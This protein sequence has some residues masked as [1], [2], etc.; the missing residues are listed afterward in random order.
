MELNAISKEITDQIS[1]YVEANEF[2]LRRYVPLA[3][4]NRIPYTGPRWNKDE[5]REFCSRA[6]SG[7][8]T[9]VEMIEHL[10]HCQ[11][12]LEAL[13][14]MQAFV[15]LKYG[16]EYEGPVVSSDE[17]MAIIERAREIEASELS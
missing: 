12:V 5:T 11:E 17:T 15:M 7:D 8:A 10:Q 1:R 3:W 16:G 6:E 14:K 13:C 2:V 9:L 4:N